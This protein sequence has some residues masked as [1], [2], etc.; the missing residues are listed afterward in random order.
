MNGEIFK[1]VITDTCEIKACGFDYWLP[2]T[3]ACKYYKTCTR[4][5]NKKEKEKK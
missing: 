4:N 2:C 5:R 1:K 3:T